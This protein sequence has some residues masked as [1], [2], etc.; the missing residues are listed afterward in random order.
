MVI[1]TSLGKSILGEHNTIDGASFLGMIKPYH[2][3]NFA[4]LCPDFNVII[5]VFLLKFYSLVIYVKVDATL[6]SS[7]SLYCKEKI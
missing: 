5:R 3:Q 6:E 1:Y 4:L 2:P 7:N